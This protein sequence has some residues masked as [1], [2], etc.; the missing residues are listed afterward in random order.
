MIRPQPKPARGDALA[1]RYIAQWR[2]TTARLQVLVNTRS[3][4]AVL[5]DEA[6]ALRRQCERLAAELGHMADAA[7]PQPSQKPPAP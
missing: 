7:R 5:T 4:A 1:R 2:R 3:G 6:H